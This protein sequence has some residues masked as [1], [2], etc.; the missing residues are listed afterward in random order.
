HGAETAAM[1]NLILDTFL[2]D[3]RVKEEDRR[4]QK[5]RELEAAYA[6][7]KDRLDRRKSE[8]RKL[9]MDSGLQDLETARALFGAILTRLN[10]AEKDLSDAGKEQARLSEELR[11]LQ[12]ALLD[13]PKRAISD[14]QLDDALR[15]D[16]TAQPLFAEI[17]KVETEVLQ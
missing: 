16:P 5:G 13:L 7:R 9:E 6:K 3:L 8:L 2:K 14:K 12:K 4:R 15:I 10:N 17:A 11:N 1:L